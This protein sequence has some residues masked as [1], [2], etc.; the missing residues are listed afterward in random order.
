MILIYTN[1]GPIPFAAVI[2]VNVVMFVGIFSRMIPA[3]ALMTAIPEVTKRGAFNAVSS[4][5]QQVSGGIASVIA[6]LIVAQDP[7]GHILHFNILGYVVSC[8][9]L[10]TLTLMYRIHRSIRE[11]PAK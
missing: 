5:V 2:A 6:G 7:D 9:S 1:L 8:V 3:Q 10:V 4:S 11:R